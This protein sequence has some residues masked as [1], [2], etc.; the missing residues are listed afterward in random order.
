MLARCSRLTASLAKSV[1]SSQTKTLLKL[2][3]PVKATGSPE[4]IYYRRTLVGPSSI[5]LPILRFLGFWY[6]FFLKFAESQFL[7]K[8]TGRT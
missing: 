8:P 7:L 2:P 5:F 6:S 4:A 3:S 1:L